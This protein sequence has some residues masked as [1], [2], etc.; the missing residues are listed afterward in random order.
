MELILW[1]HAEAKSVL[2]D[3]DRS[4]NT[5]GRK[6][7][8]RTAMWLDANLPENCRILVSPEARAVQTAEALGRKFRIHP[9]VGPDA[10]P[11]MILAAVNWPHSKET[12]MVVGHQPALGQVAA[13]LIAGMQQDWRIRR[14]SAWWIAQRKDTPADAA[15]FVRA[16]VSPDLTAPN[17]PE[18]R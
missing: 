1:R 13:L 12:V 16:V 8:N 17:L 7:A 14:G 5:K 10:T 11:E 9:D 3:E 6:Q 15:N 4:L 2:P 18:T